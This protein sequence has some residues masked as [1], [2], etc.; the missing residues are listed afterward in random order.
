VL[1]NSNSVSASSS[2]NTIWRLWG[3]VGGGSEKNEDCRYTASMTSVVPRDGHAVAEFFIGYGGVLG[4]TIAVVSFDSDTSR[5]CFSFVRC[6]LSFC[7][8]GSR[9]GLL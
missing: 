6:S 3:S 9:D 7:F 1:R 4:D 5:L 8:D 2:V